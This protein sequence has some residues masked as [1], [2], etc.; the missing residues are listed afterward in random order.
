[1]AIINNEKCIGCGTCVNYCPLGAISLKD[2]KA[3]IDQNVCPNCFVCIRNKVCPFDAIEKRETPTFIE[4]FQHVISDPVETTDKTG[5]PG[6]GTEESKTND[7]TGRVKRG[8]IGICIDMGRPGLGCRLRDVEK[9]AMAVT[10]AGLILE[11]EGTTPLAMLMEDNSRGKI[12]DK[13][14]DVNVL[15]IIIEGNCS[16]QSFPAVIA[17]LKTVEKQIETV[18]SLG[19]V[20]RVDGN[21]HNPILE[22]I[23]KLKL[24]KPYRGKINVG[25]GR[26]LITD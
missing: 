26:P 7:V 16:V 5:V 19:V 14:L 25:L 6:R 2:K 15:S 10:A 23:E 3:V 21:G 1:M 8:E 22:E 9:V 4:Q 11:D 20:V 18:F 13:Y 24:A 17:A 12:K